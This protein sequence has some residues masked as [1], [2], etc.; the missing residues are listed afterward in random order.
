MVFQWSPQNSE[1]WASLEQVIG[2][3]II[4]VLI[5]VYA[6]NGIHKQDDTP[7]QINFLDASVIFL[8]NHSD[9]ES[10]R[11][12][13]SGWIDPFNLQTDQKVEN[14]RQE[15]GRWIQ[16]DV[17]R[18]APFEDLIGKI[19]KDVH[20]IFNIDGKLAGAQFDV[21]SITFSFVVG[22]DESNI[23]WGIQNPVLQKKMYTAIRS[24]A[25]KDTCT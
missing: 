21:D 13:K 3:Q 20:P 7:L 6:I 14:N 23:I 19:I 2:R 16:K 25:I 22:F 4:S 18:E 5:N 10:L 15:F 8:D 24:L 1:M 17:S 9:G 12:N 11:V